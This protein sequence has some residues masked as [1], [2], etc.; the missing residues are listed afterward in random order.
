MINQLQLMMSTR[1]K[2]YKNVCLCSCLKEVHPGFSS[3][4]DQSIFIL[5]P[6]WNAR[7]SQ[8]YPLPPLNIK[9]AGTHTFIDLG[10][11]EGG[12]VRVIKSVLA[13]NTA[14]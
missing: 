8:R 2:H 3:T 13:N 6:R 9:S 11:D 1:S 7:P 12:I 10:G 14:Q 5:P 4:S